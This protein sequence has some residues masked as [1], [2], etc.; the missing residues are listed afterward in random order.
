M[1][2]IE[3]GDIFEINTPKGKAYLHYIALNVVGVEI[4][5]VLPGLYEKE[6]KDLMVVATAD[7]RYMVA[8]PVAAAARKKIVNKVGHLSANKYKKPKYMRTK[9]CIGKDI[10]GWHIVDTDSMKRQF[11]EKLT[12][13]QQKLSPWGHWNDTLLIENLVDNWS[14]K[15]WK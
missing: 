9:N 1:K 8:F 6:P 15:K 10:K 3:L 13:E 12:P 14:L 2:K 7:E 11:V 5:R 4:I